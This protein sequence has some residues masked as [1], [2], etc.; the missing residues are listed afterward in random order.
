MSFDSQFQRI[1]GVRFFVGESQQAIDHVSSHGGLV[2]VP[3]APALKNLPV[4]VAYREALLGADFAITDMVNG[5]HGS[6]G[7]PAGALI[8][9]DLGDSGPERLR[10]FAFVLTH[11][12]DTVMGAARSMMRRI[13]STSG[14]PLVASAASGPSLDG[15]A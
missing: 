2:V 5:R 14:Y 13:T 9:Q 7:E 11:D 6:Q 4:D 12:Y 10:R 15:A 8:A 1:L 3:A